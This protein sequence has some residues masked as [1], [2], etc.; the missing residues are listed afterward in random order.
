MIISV[1]LLFLRCLSILI[2]LCA[3]FIYVCTKTLK[4]L[5]LDCRKPTDVCPN[6]S[7]VSHDILFLLPTMVPPLILEVAVSVLHLNI[8]LYN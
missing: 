4:I 8:A 6:Q 2:N 1:I 7:C 3:V 5:Y